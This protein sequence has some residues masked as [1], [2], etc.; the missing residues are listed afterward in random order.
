M[1]FRSLYFRVSCGSFWIIL[2]LS[3]E[4][5]APA[6]PLSQDKRKRNPTTAPAGPTSI[7]AGAPTERF[8]VPLVRGACEAGRPDDDPW[9][10]LSVKAHS[11]ARAVL[12]Q[13]CFHRLVPP[14]V[15]R[16][17]TDIGRKFRTETAPDFIKPTLPLRDA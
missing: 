6:D 10:P 11:D 9:Y 13:A 5:W 8:A 4:W 17:N 7:D 3:D 12:W 16:L 15:T 1:L 2:L 14:P